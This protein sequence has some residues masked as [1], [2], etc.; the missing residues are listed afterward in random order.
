MFKEINK[1]WYELIRHVLLLFTET[2]D[3]FCEEI[4]GQV[5]VCF[6]LVAVFESTGGT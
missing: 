6:H 2:E 1:V 5:W 3:V 4:Y